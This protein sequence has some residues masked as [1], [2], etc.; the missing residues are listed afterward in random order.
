MTA[1]ELLALGLT[2][3]DLTRAIWFFLDQLE[4]DRVE[5]LN[6]FGDNT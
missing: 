5:L 6:S 3:S 1:S 2:E 4:Q